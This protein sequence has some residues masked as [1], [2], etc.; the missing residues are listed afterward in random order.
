DGQQA[1]LICLSHVGIGDGGMMLGDDRRAIAAAS[2]INKEAA[3]PGVVGMK[4]QAE[5]ALLVAGGGNHV[6]QIQENRGGS[7]SGLGHLDPAPCSTTKIRPVPSPALVTN[8]GFEKPVRYQWS[9]IR[10]W[11]T[12]Q[13]A[14]PKT[15]TTQIHP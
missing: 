4:R 13:K 3:I 8:F 6:A 5:E 11:P 7:S 14:K 15:G 10:T 12:D 9:W 2:V 1:D